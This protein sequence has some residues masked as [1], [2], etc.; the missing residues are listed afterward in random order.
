MGLALAEIYATLLDEGTYLCSERTMYRL[1]AAE[2]DVR[3]RRA[4]RH[5]PVYQAP[6]F[7]IPITVQDAE[8]PARFPRAFRLNPARTKP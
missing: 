5:H 7:L 6:E 8:V 1:L 2:G 3:E 4:Q